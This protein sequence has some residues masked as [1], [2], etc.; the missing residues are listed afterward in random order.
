LTLFAVLPG[1]A[2]PLQTLDALIQTAG[3]LA[4]TLRGVVQDSKGVPLSQQR[5]EALRED[6]ARF[7]AMLTMS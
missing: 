5:A 4:E 1:P 7:Q 2:E 6:V 3:E